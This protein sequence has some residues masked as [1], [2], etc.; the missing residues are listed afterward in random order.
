MVKGAQPIDENIRWFLYLNLH[1][2]DKSKK[3]M[4]NF[5]ILNLVM[6]LK[7]WKLIGLLELVQ[8]G[9]HFADDIFECIFLNEIIFIL[10]QISLKFVPKGPIDNILS[11]IGTANALVQIWQQA[12]I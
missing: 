11:S 2:N 7:L 5:F 6:K 12:V 4:D 8:N 10:I 9:H 1:T 3:Q